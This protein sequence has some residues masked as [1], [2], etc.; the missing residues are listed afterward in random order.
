[1]PLVQWGEYRP[2][3]AD[4]LGT[5]NRSLLNVLPQGDGYGP[6]Q[7]FAQFSGA[8]PAACRGAFYALRAD[9]SVAVF[10]GTSDRLYLL[11]N[12]TLTWTPVGKVAALTSI[13]N[14]SPAVVSY[15]GHPF[16]VNDPV[17]FSTDGAL[18]AGL[19]A[20]TVYYV[21]SAGLTSSAFQVSE[22][23]GGAAVNTSSAGSGTHSV[24]STY[25]A[26]NADA[27]W[28]FAQFN[29]LV[30]AVQEN[31]APQ[32]YT[33]GSSS[34]FADLGG[35]PPQAAYVDIVGRFV[36][37]SGLA[38]NK[39]R[40]QWSGLNAPTTWTSGTNSSDY[41]DLPDGGIVRGVA[42]GESGVIF[43]DQAIRRMMYVPGSPLIFQIERMTQDHGLYAPYSLVRASDK[44]FF[45]SAKGFHR[46]DPGSHPVQIGRE[47]VDRTF[48]ADIDK[49]NLQLFHGAAD[50]RSS[51]VFWAY[52][53]NSGT[54]GLY[55][56]ILGYDFALDRWFALETSGEYL[57]SMSQTGITL[58]SLDALSS[59]IDAMT[60]SFDNYATSVTPELA[61]FNSAHKLGFFRGDN[62]EA[63]FETAEQGAD[64][65]RLFVRGFRPITDASSVYGSLR[66]RDKQSETPTDGDEIAMHS[67]TGSCDRLKSTRYTRFK[68]RIPAGTTWTFCAGV[69]PDV[70]T[71]GKH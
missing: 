61:Q 29:T 8:L 33:L 27:Q 58:E 38:S 37:L 40:I 32:L 43:Q 21:I 44:I 2:D 48:F 57:L 4:Y 56:K 17:V 6:F 49:G 10:A 67:T 19:T 45:F 23:L 64:G 69:E 12:T 9:G 70:T 39:T 52:K 35:S 53:S 7:E 1:M 15:T 20:G 46:I 65:R 14:A 3:V 47:R 30:I 5:A 59:S 60:S 25:T 28:R 13:S 31:C 54:T 55:D 68:A 51:R 42:G 63:T 66:H 36:V 16:A 41:Q 50:P 18:P 71:E 62:L 22:T 34:A 11:N 24:T 26:L